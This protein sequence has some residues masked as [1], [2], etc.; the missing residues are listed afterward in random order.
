MNEIPAKCLTCPNV[1][2]AQETIAEHEERIEAM[3]GRLMSDTID[4][5][6]GEQFAKHPE[7]AEDYGNRTAAELA[8][9]FRKLGNQQVEVLEAHTEQHRVELARTALNCSGVI[10]LHG[11][12]DDTTVDVVVCNSP[13]FER[14][15]GLV[16]DLTFTDRQHKS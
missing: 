6:I 9:E 16:E 10:E 8:A 13:L 2:Q 14:G 12:N 15:I 5:E 11:E 4:N 1:K 7:L 3:L